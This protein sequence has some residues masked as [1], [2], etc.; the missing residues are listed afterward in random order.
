MVLIH[1]EMVEVLLVNIK[2]IKCMEA[3]LSLGRMVGYTE[4]NTKT[5][6]KKVSVS[7]PGQRGSN[8]EDS[9]NMEYSR[10]MVY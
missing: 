7:L 9:G 4:V 8:T 5:A 6:R 1:G 3:G 2:I 10:A